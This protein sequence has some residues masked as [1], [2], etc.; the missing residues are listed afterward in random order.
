MTLPTEAQLKT[1]SR[2]ELIALATVKLL[3]ARVTELEVEL[4]K[5]RQ[6]PATSRN[7]SAPPSHDLAAAAR[8]WVPLLAIN[9]PCM[10]GWT[11]RIGS[12]KPLSR[13]AR[14]VRR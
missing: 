12:S 11:T 14:T 8:R 9:V 13:A 6:P 3:Q 5:L 7:S 10:N 4:A 2:E 1:L